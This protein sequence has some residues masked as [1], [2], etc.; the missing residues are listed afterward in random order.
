[1]A[2][3]GRAE[4]E[5][6][7]VIKGTGQHRVPGGQVGTLQARPLWVCCDSV[8]LRKPVPLTQG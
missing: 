6:P 8:L 1:M 3:V 4:A 5:S 2:L 7:V